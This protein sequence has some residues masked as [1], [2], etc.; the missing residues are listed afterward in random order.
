VD[1]VI[2][3]EDHGSY[4]Q[5]LQEQIQGM[6]I[7]EAG[8]SQPFMKKGGVFVKSADQLSPEDRIL[9]ESV[10]RVIIYDNRG[11]LVDQVNRRN[12]A[13]N[14][15][16]IIEMKSM[17]A[18]ESEPQ[19]SLPENLLFF[20]GMGGFSEDGNTY[21]ILTDQK[22]KTPAPWVNVIANPEFGSVVSDQ[23]SAYTW[24][25]N[26][27]AYRIT[28][29]NN[30]PVSDIGGEAFY[31]RD[32]DFGN[33]WSP[34]PYPVSSQKPYLISHGFGFSTFRHINRGIESEMK[35]FVDK[36]DPIKFIVIKLKNHS[37]NERLLTL[38]GYMEIILGDLKS[39]TN[40]HILS[41]VDK[42]S[43][44]LLFRNRYNSAFADQVSFFKTDA[45]NFSYTTDRTVFLGRNENLLNPH[46]L[47]RKRLSGRVGAGID[48]CAALQV[49]VSLLSG[50]EKEVVFMLGSSHNLTAAHQLLNKYATKAAVESSFGELTEYW[51]A[52]LGLVQVHTPDKA[53]NVLANGWLPYQTL[54]C[55]IYA[56]SGFYQSGGAFGFRDQ[57]QDV[58][59]LLNIQ[60]E[61]AR[62]QILLSASRQFV[63]G[64]VQH[65]WHP[66]EGRG[67]RTKCSDDMLWLPF[68]VSKYVEVTGDISIL[69]EEVGFLESR[70][71]TQDEE[72]LYELPH[73]GNQS[74]SLYDHCMRAITY[75][76]SFGAH[77]LPLIGAGDW[78]DG[79]DMVGHKGKGESVW[80]GFFLF[81]VMRRFEDVAEA[82]GDEAFRS[83]CEDEKQ[84]L[85][86]RIEASSWD[87]NWYKRA[88]FDDG[89][90]L[91]SAA[92]DECQIDAI[93]QSW[94]VLSQA[95]DPER[96]LQGMNSLNERLVRRDLNLIQ[97]LD[98][99]FDKG[100][101]NP[102]YIK[103]Y[104]PGVR[105]NGGQYSHAA[106]WALMAFA[107]LGDRDKVWELFQ[108]IQPIGHADTEEKMRI[109]K[110]EPYVMAADVY[111]NES[112]KGRGGWTWY[113]GSSG[114]M[115][116]FIINSLIGMEIRAG[117][118][119]FK[120]C[121][122][123]DWP[124]VYV[125]QFCGS[126]VYHIDVFQITD[127]DSWWDVDGEKGH[128]D[129]IQMVDDGGEHQVKLHIKIN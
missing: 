89:T 120:P 23:G 62:N 114:W 92:N 27:H 40:M 33:F 7:G 128:G 47:H 13:F 87:G 1:L 25:R 68:V 22:Q 49:K 58:L 24:A 81:D 124:S 10:A 91:G 61:T 66:P 112:H 65:W 75:S 117:K 102:G 60:P 43:G 6:V 64:D 125:R 88:F 55:R 72:S 69:D 41:E 28:P 97:L 111:A 127:R 44:A 3:N 9:F 56:R 57:L 59:A 94:A 76:L 17:E 18:L 108:L 70:L 16:P 5:L 101:L 48:S 99:P 54:A 4:R 63:E 98:P 26:A 15:P 20:N 19:L 2:W 85:Q 53:L 122:P 123:L 96:A 105:E 93:A 84:M 107:A 74:G 8:I 103:G 52:T 71:L 36:T 110:V 129:S 11:S 116:Q 106:V 119:S 95:G 121:F 51:K 45:A 126:S 104:V 80:L 82:Y 46:A 38:T 73:S 31:I 100:G 14:L 78:N 21:H 29:W 109:Y 86:K 30:D 79:M 39:K 35:M 113:T 50:E 90:P 83:R 37:G 32:E 115:Y 67:V 77:G 42:R 12:T 34:A 118:I